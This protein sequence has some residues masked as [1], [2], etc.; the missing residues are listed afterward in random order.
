MSERKFY[1][2]IT[3]IVVGIML[4][5]FYYIT[6]WDDSYYG[7]LLLGDRVIDA[8][9][10]QNETYLE[11]SKG[12]MAK[13][14]FPSPADVAQQ[15]VVK[16]RYAEE[17]WSVFA[18]EETYQYGYL[19]IQYDESAYVQEKENLLSQ[20]NTQT[21]EECG[22]FICYKMDSTYENVWQWVCFC[23]EIKVI[24]YVITND[25][26]IDSAWDTPV[27]LFMQSEWSVHDY[28]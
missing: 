16:F 22:D 15:T 3:A 9:D 26:P 8:E 28:K 24:Q 4:F 18:R 20:V 25:Y 7:K 17:P 10:Y 13:E 14:F 6:L 19:V 1:L 21:E 11:Y 23:D 12:Y 5:G 27:T 2:C